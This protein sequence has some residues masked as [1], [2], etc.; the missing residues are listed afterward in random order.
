MAAQGAEAG[1]SVAVEHHRAVDAVL[2][3][4]RTGQRAVFGDV[5]NHHDRHAA[6]FGEARQ[7]SR[8]FAHLRHATRRG[9]NVRHVHNLDGVDDHQLRLLFIGNH[10]NLFNAGFRQHVEITGRQAETVCAHCH[11]LQGFFT[12]DIQGFHLLREL[13]QSLQQQRRFTRPWITADQDRTA[14]HHSAA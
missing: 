7:I 9:L 10:A 13:T 3:H 12:G 8:G 5:T 14:R 6:R 4:F 1:I 11:L 2:Q